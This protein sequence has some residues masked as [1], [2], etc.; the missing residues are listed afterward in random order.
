MIL[1]PAQE[2]TL[3]E[4]WVDSVTATGLKAVQDS[5]YADT[6]N[7]RSY[8]SNCLSAGVFN[9]TEAFYLNQIENVFDSLQY[10]YDSATYITRIKAI[11]SEV[12]TNMTDSTRAAP[13]GLAAIARGS[14]VYWLAQSEKPMSPW[15]SCF[16]G[17]PQHSKYPTTQ[18]F[19]DDF[20]AVAGKDFG[21]FVKGVGVACASNIVEVSFFGGPAA[22]GTTLGIAGFAG[23]VGASS[24][25]W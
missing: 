12:L 19:W 18:G 10:G 22:T 14:Y 4:W 24:G 5:V 8:I 21:G 17:H 2:D 1:P 3:Q 15:P 20:G 13:L 7:L 23:G 6:T 25:W 11:E 9:P 16:S